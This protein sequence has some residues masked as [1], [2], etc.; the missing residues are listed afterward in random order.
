MH[1]AGRELR[2][3]PGCQGSSVHPL[4]NDWEKAV[5]SGS[6]GCPMTQNSADDGRPRVAQWLQCVRWCSGWGSPTDHHHHHH[7]ML[8]C[9]QLVC[10]GGVLYSLTEHSQFL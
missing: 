10:N 9:I 7:H 1:H 6:G 5:L 8:V 3:L 2:H 4:G